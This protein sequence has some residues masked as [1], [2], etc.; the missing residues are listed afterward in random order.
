MSRSATIVISYLMKRFAEMN[1]EKALRYVKSKRP[2]VNPN[3]GFIRQLRNYEKVLIKERFNEKLMPAV[4]IENEMNNKSKKDILA[5]IN[6][7]QFED[8]YSKFDRN[9]LKSRQINSNNFH[10]TSGMASKHG[11]LNN[12]KNEEE[13]QVNKFVINKNEFNKKIFNSE[14][15]NGVQ[16]EQP[17]LEQFLNLHRPSV[18]QK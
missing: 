1:L 10:F 17:V 18:F 4:D 14:L 3:D 15:L 12:I 9:D 16:K 11:Y 6:R 5:N 7:K 2:I 8:L 13:K